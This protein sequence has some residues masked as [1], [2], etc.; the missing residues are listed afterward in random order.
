MLF[1]EGDQLAAEAVDFE[2]KPAIDF[3]QQQRV[4]L[5][6]FALLE[7]CDHVFAPRIEFAPR[8]FELRHNRLLTIGKRRRV[9]HRRDPVA[10]ARLR[11]AVRLLPFAAAPIEQV[12]GK[13]VV[14]FQN[15]DLGVLDADIRK[16]LAAGL[17]QSPVNPPAP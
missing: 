17:V 11:L 13:Q 4:C 8:R 9:P 16:V 6:L 5:L 7:K 3:P 14:S 10:K 15:R 2:G 12:V 1:A